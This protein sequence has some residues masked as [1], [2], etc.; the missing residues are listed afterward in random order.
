LLSKHVSITIHGQ[1][2]KYL[3]SQNVEVGD[4][5]NHIV[6][7]FDNRDTVAAN[8]TI[9]GLNIVEVSVRGIAELTNKHGGGNATY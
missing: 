9:N 4:V 6:R 2:I 3:V 5:P 1:S 8:V 7:V